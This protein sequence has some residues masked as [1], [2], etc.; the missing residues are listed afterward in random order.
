MRFRV[1]LRS[2]PTGLCLQAEGRISLPVSGLFPCCPR[3]KGCCLSRISGGRCG[4]SRSLPALLLA[5]L[6][7]HQSPAL[8]S[9]STLAV[10]RS[11]NSLQEFWL[12]FRSCFL[13]WTSPC[14]SA[15]A[16]TE[17]LRE[18]VGGTVDTSLSW[19]V[20]VEV[21]QQHCLASASNAISAC[22]VWHTHYPSSC[23]C[24]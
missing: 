23:R 17:L 14:C 1:P 9:R 8:C 4:S 15:S 20:K 7:S 12:S 13:S 18:I 19:V 6:E 2:H 24:I 21:S 22:S 5:H 10:V 16:R 3:W 11:T